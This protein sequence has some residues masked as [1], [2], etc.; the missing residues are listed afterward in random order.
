MFRKDR[1]KVEEHTK[2]NEEEVLAV[3]PVVARLPDY[4]HARRNQEW[5]KK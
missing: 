4:A 5:A 1:K 2:H 3:A